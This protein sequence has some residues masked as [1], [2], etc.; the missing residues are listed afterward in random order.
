MTRI[1]VTGGTGRIGLPLVTK[2]IALG[3]AVRVLAL[4]DDRRAADADSAGAEILVGSV[5]APESCAD[6]VDDVEVVYHLAGQLP[7][8]ASDESIFETNVR[9]T[10]NLL[11]ATAERPEPLSLFVFES[12]EVVFSSVDALYVPVD[13]NHP[14]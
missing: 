3:H 12:T 7:Q 10:W 4:P 5:T 2:L 9:G 1:L 11:K 6:A 8:R 14:R 13:E